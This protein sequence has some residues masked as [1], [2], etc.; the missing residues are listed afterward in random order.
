MVWLSNGEVQRIMTAGWVFQKKTKKNQKNPK[1]MRSHFPVK[2][3][4]M[5]SWG[6]CVTVIS[7]EF[8]RTASALY[9][10]VQLVALNSSGFPQKF[11]SLFAVA[12]SRGTG[13]FI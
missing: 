1:K 11:L 4:E 2:S 6:V 9:F 3:R 13:R 10:E 8:K 5:R 7:T 12:P